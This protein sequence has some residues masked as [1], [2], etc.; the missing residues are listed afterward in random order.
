MSILAFGTRTPN[1]DPKPVAYFLTALTFL[2]VAVILVL[3][4]GLS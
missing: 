4:L 3:P 2:A 1:H